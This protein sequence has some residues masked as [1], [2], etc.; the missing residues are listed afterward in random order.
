MKTALLV[1]DVQKDYFPGGKMELT[2]STEASERIKSMIAHFRKTNR[3]VI[4]VQHL[5]AKPD[6]P[7]FLPGTDGTGFHENSSPEDGEKTVRKNYPNSFRKT[8]LDRYCKDHGIDTLVV[9]GMMT[10]MCVDTTVRAAFDLG[11]D[12]VVLA[13]CCATKNLKIDD[14]I[15]AAGHVQDSFLAALNGTFAKVMNSKEYIKLEGI[16]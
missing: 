12:C 10:H 7:F 11:Y 13:D 6:A 15:I 8:D 3:P 16:R 5:S 1:I 2:G 14:R 9:V 4:H